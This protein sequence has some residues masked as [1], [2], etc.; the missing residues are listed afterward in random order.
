M[1]E[2]RHYIIDDIMKINNNENIKKRKFNQFEKENTTNNIN[3]NM[4]L[5][6]SKNL[7][8]NDNIFQH[9]SKAKKLSTIYNKN[10]KDINNIIDNNSTKSLLKSNKKLNINSQNNNKTGKK[11]PLRV[12]RFDPSNSNIIR[13]NVNFDNNNIISN[14]F[15]NLKNVKRGITTDTYKYY[16]KKTSTSKS[17]IDTSVN[18]KSKRGSSA[19]SSS[20]LAYCPRM[21]DAKS[22]KKVI[23]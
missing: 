11:I 20:G 10:K 22:M 16:T 17:R 1:D 6:M 7:S 23:I 8:G 9:Q 5:N 14:N 19:T 15:S 4:N 12:N 2:E 21:H 3:L 13:N 18:S